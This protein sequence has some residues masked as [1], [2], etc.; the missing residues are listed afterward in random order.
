MFPKTQK[1]INQMIEQQI[2]PGAVYSFKSLNSEATFTKGN[3]QILPSIEPM[4]E[5]TL[6]DVASLTKVVGTNSVVLKLLEEKKMKL[7]QSIKHYLPTFEDDSVTILEL[8]THTSAINGFIPNRDQLSQT[9]LIEAFNHLNVDH[10]SKGKNVVYTDTGTILLGF[11]IE[12]L[13]QE[14]IQ[15]IIQKQIIEPLELSR[16]TFFPPKDECAP[17]NNL[18][19]SEQ[20]LYG[21][22]HDTKAAVLKEHCGSAGL[23]SDINDLNRFCYMMMNDGQIGETK[24]L[25][26]ETIQSLNQT[27]SPNADKHRSLG[28]DLKWHP[29]KQH[30]ILF[31]TGYTGTF[32]LIDLNEKRS[33]VFLSNRVHPQDHR[34]TYMTHRDELVTIYLE[35]VASH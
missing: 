34:E 3:K 23:F 11:A 22:V 12:Q 33:F 1:K 5:Q 35:E 4:T 19:Q 31:H 6:F 26:K 10:A 17:T 29:N 24:F 9:E 13:L 8:L 21:I 14:P 27:W 18:I 25:T 2:I 16:S 15:V 28:W 32:I 7:D 20:P 30:P